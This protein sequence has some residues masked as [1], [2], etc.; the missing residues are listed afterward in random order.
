MMQKIAHKA[1]QIECIRLTKELGDDVDGALIMIDRKTGEIKALV[2]GFDFT[3]SK[4]NRAFQARRQI[5]SI[6]KPLVY[7]AALQ[8]SMTFAD[9]EIDEP[10]ELMQE[11]KS[12]CP[13]NYNKKFNGQV[14]L[15]Y[16]LSHS[17]NIV[18]IKTL[19]RTG[20]FK[21][22]ELAKKCRLEGPF[23]SYPSLALGCI[24]ATL[25]EAVGMFNVFSNDGIYI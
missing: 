16:A 21:V 25:K 11:T 15:A 1:F 5:G 10:I 22:V 19:L 7:T 12:W 17:S 3:T 13:R 2:G 18:A 20:I 24:D 6:F 9:T 23:H 4:F 14:T 8:E